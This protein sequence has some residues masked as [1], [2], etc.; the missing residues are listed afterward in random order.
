[1]R[2]R[3]DS[4]R[5]VM[6]LCLLVFLLEST[7]TVAQEADTVR[8]VDGNSSSEGRVEVFHD[9]EWGTICS[10]HWGPADA[11]VL[12]RQLGYGF[13]HS[14]LAHFGEGHGPIL[15]DDVRCS[16]YDGMIEYCD[17]KG[18]GNHNCNHTQDVGVV[19]SEHFIYNG[20]T[21]ITDELRFELKLIDSRF[22][23]S[24]FLVARYSPAKE[25]GAICGDHWD[26]R[27]AQVTCRHLGYGANIDTKGSRLIHESAIPETTMFS[28]VGCQGD[29]TELWQ[30]ELVSGAGVTCETLPYIECQTE[31]AVFEDPINLC[32]EI[33]YCGFDCYQGPRDTLRHDLDAREMC[34]CDDACVYFEDCCYDYRTNCDPQPDSGRDVMNGVD[35]RYYA[36]V[37]TLGMDLVERYDHYFGVALVSFCPQQWTGPDFLKLECEQMPSPL[38]VIASLPVF[39]NEGAVYKN[40]FC[41]LCHG[42]DANEIHK[43]TAR[44][45]YY[46]MPGSTYTDPRL[47]VTIIDGRSTGRYVVE[48]PEDGSGG[49]SRTCPLSTIGSCLQEF[50]NSSQEAACKEY[51][52]PTRVN[53]VRYKNPHCAMC[54]GEI[55]YPIDTCVSLCPLPECSHFEKWEPCL[56][57]ICFGGPGNILTV[58][59]MFD[60]GWSG[61]ENS[62]CRSGELYDPFLDRCRVVTCAAGFVLADDGQCLPLLETFF[63]IPP[64]PQIPETLNEECHSIINDT[65]SSS[66]EVVHWR[67]VLLNG[68]QSSD[69]SEENYSLSI[70]GRSFETLIKDI[71]DF[72]NT[73]KNHTSEQ[74]NC[75]LH[76]VTVYTAQGAGLLSSIDV[77]ANST[78]KSREV[79][80]PSVENETVYDVEIIRSFR[81]T[82]QNSTFSR[83]GLLPTEC[84]DINLLNCSE[85]VER[86]TA[87][88]YVS[89]PA[90][91]SIRHL[92]TGLELG[93]GE[94]VTL[95][96]R[97]AIICSPVDWSDPSKYA[98]GF[99]SLILYCLSLLALLATFVT[100]CV[101]LTL[102]NMAGFQTMNLLVALFVAILLIVLAGNLSVSGKY[103]QAMAS[104]THLSW[105]A[106]FFWMAT[107]SVNAAKTFGSRNILPR[108][109]QPSSRQLLTTM[110][111]IWGTALL[112]VVVG[113]VLNFCDCTSLPA[114]YSESP[115]CWIPNVN[116]LLVG[117]VAPV[118]VS[119]LIS[120]SSFIFVIVR[121]R[122][123]KGE[124]KMVQKKGNLEEV[125]G[126]L[127]IYVKLALLFGVCWLLAF[128]SVAVNH[129]ILS[130]INVIV[131]SL[132]G[133]F[134]F[135]AFCLNRRVR[136]LWRGRLLGRDATRFEAGRTKVGTK[137]SNSKEKHAVTATRTTTVSSKGPKTKDIKE[138]TYL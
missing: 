23:A 72:L 103:C 3:R 47:N 130:Y 109:S 90:S 31:T 104:V 20:N 2:N 98:L 88:E 134:I 116:I 27:D 61:G 64:L 15:L 63:P 26:Y 48:P 39:D 73:F 131:N 115:P 93:P 19:C 8:L 105:L 97:T 74:S 123:M 62:A 82:Q 7:S 107:L 128:V 56:Q 25:W 46:T 119:L 70:L 6:P 137:A 76:L 53:Y 30:C 57:D 84:T 67:L 54:N 21:V 122:K 77:C 129:V 132:Q 36:C 111:F 94:F 37:S 9:G 99:L 51:F 66:S 55:V 50:S 42:V 5:C 17:H 75:N 117:F 126:E 96:D 33:N 59:A 68:T 11:K 127:K 16:Q 24:G 58:E 110:M 91:Q 87:D 45:E 108:G 34:K 38:D 89:Q 112:I 136:A 32:G 92:P 65:L 28:A 83:E 18:W 10:D 22:E 133:V 113:L 12:C 69:L 118:A 60:F 49:I 1:M 35:L 138:E 124:S 81:W 71:G 80:D 13:V 106:A 125:L 14:D 101:F 135:M 4:I 52:A 100:Y 114:V 79:F 40:I 43:W 121:V 44:L 86:L 102:R 29:E 41:A 120:V 78:M 95:S 85:M